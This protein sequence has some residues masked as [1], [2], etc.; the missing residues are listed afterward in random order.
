MNKKITLEI[1]END[2]YVKEK[3]LPRLGESSRYVNLLRL[4]K[5]CQ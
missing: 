2:F 5:F 4:L 1:V 3:W